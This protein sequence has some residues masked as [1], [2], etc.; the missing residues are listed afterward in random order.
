MYK[1]PIDHP[2]A[3]ESSENDSAFSV[4]E[5]IV[6]IVLFIIIIITLAYFESIFSHI[7]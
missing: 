2:A 7:K 3:L 1:N 5:T 4:S 6:I